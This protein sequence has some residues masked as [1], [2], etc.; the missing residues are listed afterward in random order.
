MQKTGDLCS[1]QCI[2][3]CT[4]QYSVYSM[5]YIAHTIL[6]RAPSSVQCSMYCTPY[7]LQCIFQ[8]TVE[9]AVYIAPCTVHIIL[10]SAYFSVL[11]IIQTSVWHV[12]YRLYLVGAPISVQ[13]SI[14]CTHH[15]C[16]TVH[17]SLNRSS[18]SVQY[19]MYFGPV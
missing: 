3:Q 19:F 7:F 6:Y 13:Y 17:I 10:Y 1:P 15:L 9:H 16:S 18:S 2:Y 11:Y 5:E 14:Y 12:L 8:C 4:V